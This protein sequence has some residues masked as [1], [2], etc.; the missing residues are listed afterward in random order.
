MP[1]FYIDEAG[2]VGSI[3]T[4]TGED[5]AHIARSLRMTPGEQLVLCDGRGADYACELVSVGW[6]TAEA[7]VLTVCRSETE[8]DV[9]IT[10]YASVTKGERMD[11][12]IQK[13]VE[14]GV[15]TIVPVI[16]KR[17]VSLPE[18]KSEKN[19]LQRWNKIA[20]EASKQS[21]RGRVPA[22]EG[23]TAFGDALVRAQSADLRLIAYER[24][25]RPIGEFLATG[26]AEAAIFT[27]PEGGYEEEEIRRAEERGIYPVS[28]GKR[29]LRAET[30]PLCVLSILLYEAERGGER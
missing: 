2:P 9:K 5:A 6:D 24:G 20:L 29:I 16:S 26:F 14:L 22:V 15:H 13:A 7:R 27:G 4:I 3:L 17:C 18:A 10:L 12:V 8:P 25:V 21:G 30:A 1:R 23:L 19:K 11:F 28:L